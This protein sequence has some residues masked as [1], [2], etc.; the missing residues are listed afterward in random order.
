M[1]LHYCSIGL[2]IRET[3]IAQGISQVALAELIDCSPTYVSHIENG[4]KG[5]SL[6]TFIQ[7]AK[8]LQTPADILLA[9]DLRLTSHQS[10][11]EITEVVRDCNAY[12]NR[13]MVDTLKALKATLRSHKYMLKRDR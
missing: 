8:A 6:E 7:I 10:S 9:E 1:N 13:I 3:R 4:T 5:M 2:R 12:E 11:K